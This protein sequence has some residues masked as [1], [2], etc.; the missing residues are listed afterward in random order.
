MLNIQNLK[1]HRQEVIKKKK[2]EL[3]SEPRI[4]SSRKEGRKPMIIQE[5][6]KNK[7]MCNDFLAQLQNQ[8]EKAAF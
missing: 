5:I 7:S 1:P 4:N 2:K 3:Q 6:R 8:E